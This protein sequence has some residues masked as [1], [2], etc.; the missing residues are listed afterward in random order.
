MDTT[1]EA[2]KN[3]EF[4]IRG[5]E[6]DTITDDNHS[7]LVEEDTITDIANKISLTTGKKLTERGADKLIKFV[8]NVKL[9]QFYGK[10]Y[11]WSVNRLASMFINSTPV[12]GD[13]KKVQQLAHMDGGYFDIHALGV[14]E[15]MNTTPDEHQYKYSAHVDRR[16]NAIIDKD[17]VNG[18]SSSLS[19]IPVKKEQYMSQAYDTMKI[20][21]RFLDPNNIEEIWKRPRGWHFTYENITLPRR[22]IYLDSRNRIPGNDMRE[23]KWSLN[24]SGKPGQIG[25]VRVQDTLQQVIAMRISKGFWIPTTNSNS[26]YYGKINLLISNF[27]Q[28]TLMTEFVGSTETV[29]RERGYHFEFAAATSHGRIEL[30][31]TIETYKFSKPVAQINELD[32]VF[33]SPFQTIT[34]DADRGYFTVTTGLVTTFTSTAAHNLSTNDMIYVLNFASANTN[35]NRLMNDENGW[36]ITRDNN[37]Q[38]HIN[39]DT[40]VLAGPYTNISVYYGSKRMLIEIEFIS[41]EH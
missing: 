10:S 7:I 29:P 25:D 38:F 28:R 22:T 4:N 23:I 32:L 40:S 9:E 2:G 21:K 5:V 34:F 41:L 11:E 39:L 24:F 13:T 15:I 31:P 1:H 33:K 30:T 6:V 16:G 14:A 17:R 26:D 35:L 36:L 3:K 37:L 20:L 19:S 12:G 18:E 27:A 8:K